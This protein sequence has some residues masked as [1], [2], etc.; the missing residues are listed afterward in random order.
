[1]GLRAMSPDCEAVADVW[2]RVEY[3]V[4]AACCAAIE[5]EAGEECEDYGG[6]Q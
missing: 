5:D 1:M 2:G 4:G 6:G 3:F